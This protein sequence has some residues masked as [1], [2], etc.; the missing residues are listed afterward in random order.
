MRCGS[1]LWLMCVAAA[2]PAHA[3]S[4]ATQMLTITVRPIVSLSVPR[5]GALNLQA[6]AAGQP[7]IYQPVRLLQPK[8]LQVYHNLPGTRRVEAEAILAG[9][10]NDLDLTCATAGQPGATLIKRGVGQ[11][12]RAITGDVV[13]GFQSFDLIWETSGTAPGTPSGDYTCEVRFTLT[14]R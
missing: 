12:P 9:E 10:P 4:V 8:G 1:W 5:T 11:G 6:S 3:D 13:A 2:M 7:G 14:E